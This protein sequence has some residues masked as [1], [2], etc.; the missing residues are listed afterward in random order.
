MTE[1]AKKPVLVRMPKDM[2]DRYLKRSAMETA[3]RGETVSVPKL[4]V[5]TLAEAEAIDKPGKESENG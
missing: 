1:I 3:K 5:E 2:Y 4:I